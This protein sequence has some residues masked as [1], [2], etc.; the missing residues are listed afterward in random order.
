M[1][2]M[3]GSRDRGAG[4]S[5]WEAGQRFLEFADDVFFR[6]V[7][8]PL[9]G[10]DSEGPTEVE[11]ALPVPWYEGCAICKEDGE[12]LDAVEIVSCDSCNKVGQREVQVVE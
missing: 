4:S 5:A 12:N 7:L 1:N 11:L 3:V 6:W 9:Q 2:R 8:R 10:D